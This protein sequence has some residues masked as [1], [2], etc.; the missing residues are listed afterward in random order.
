[1]ISL[2]TVCPIRSDTVGMPSFLKPPDFF[3]I[4]TCLTG[5]GRYDP[6]DIRFHS[7]YKFFERFCSNS[8]IVSSS[9][10]AAPR[11]AFTC[12]YASHTVRFA[13]LKG[14]VDVRS[15]IPEWRVGPPRQRDNAAPSLHPH[16]KDFI[17]TTGS[18]AP[19][20]G[21]GIL[22]H[23]VCHLS[24]PFT[25]RTRFSR[26]IPK[27]VLSS[28]RLYTDCHRARK[29]VSSRLILEHR[30]GPSFDS[31]YQPNDA[32]SASLLSLIFSTRT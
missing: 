7:L 9:M 13:I 23:G 11:L 17:A 6:D 18:S 1:M 12:W 3:A 15:L 29:Q 20:S 16:Y 26:S 27:P 25:S 2:T 31:I 19:R 4:S 21:I 5:G 32:S 8:V 30:T 14:F 24:F 28:C 22:P 10:P